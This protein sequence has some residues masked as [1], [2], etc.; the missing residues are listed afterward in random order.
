MGD[1]EEIAMPKFSVIM[2]LYNKASFVRKGL[3][4]VF[5][6]TCNDWEL[7]IVNDG[8]TDDSA[9]V[10]QRCIDEYQT[11]G[12]ATCPVTMISQDNAGVGAA[13]NNGVKASSGEYVCFLD[14]DDW[15]E[16]TF[17]EEMSTFIPQ[18]SDA[19]LYACNYVY[20]KPGKTHVAVKHDTGYMNYPKLYFEQG[21]MPICNGSYAMRRTIF[22]DLDGFPIKVK[23]GEDFLL[24]CR[25]ALRHR[26]AFLNRPL[27]YYNNDVPVRLRATRNLHA[28]EN[29]MLFNLGPFEQELADSELSVDE[30]QEW[31]RLLDKLRAGGLMDYWMD[32]R[33]HDGAAIELNKV[34]WTLSPLG[35]R[36]EY[37]KP[38][39]MLKTKKKFMHLGSVFKQFII[40]LLVKR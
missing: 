21:T 2:P 9:A 26:I 40:K 39:W 33:Y 23:L 29:H 31:K 7:I 10:A 18:Y 32:A 34:D 37:K 15:W 14:A 5:A 16:P 28:P 35:V 27:V 1:S 19:G 4:S 38:I 12:G 13:R 25:V 22:E 36:D 11:S 6:Q 8:S 24:W 30:K 3:E 17:L 20:Y